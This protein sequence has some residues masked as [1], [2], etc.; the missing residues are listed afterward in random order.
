M[1]RFMVFLRAVGHILKIA[2]ILGRRLC[3]FSLIYLKIKA[4]RRDYYERQKL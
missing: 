3:T 2:R 4:E 1:K